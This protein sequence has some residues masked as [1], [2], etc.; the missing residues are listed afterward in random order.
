MEVLDD[1]IS[2]MNTRRTLLGW[3]SYSILQTIPGSESTT[4]AQLGLISIQRAR[5]TVA[6]NGSRAAHLASLR[7]QLDT[8]PKAFGY[9]GL[10]MVL[11]R[12]R[13]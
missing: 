8:F 10:Y 2:T 11:G 9:D 1:I 12:R 5:G 6:Q 4:T 3:K 7:I 13:I